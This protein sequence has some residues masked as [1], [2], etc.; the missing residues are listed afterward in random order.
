MYQHVVNELLEFMEYSGKSRQ[1]IAKET[2]ISSSAISQFLNGKYGGDNE[3]IAKNLIN[4]LKV[5]QK[6]VSAN[7]HTCFYEEL[8]NTKRV[9]V[10]CYHAH[11]RNDITLVFGDAGAGKTTALEYYRDTNAGV[12]MI[13]ANSCTAS[14][15]AILKLISQKIGKTITGKKDAL[16]N[17]LVNHFRGTNRLII[18]D[19]ADHLTIA[20]LQAVRN[21]NDEAKIGI[22]LSGNSKIYN[23]ML[24]GSKSS[25][26]QQLRTRIVVR[27]KVENLY[28]L[29]EF[30]HI[31]P[32][33]EDDCL[34]FLMEIA[35]EESLRTAVKI[36]NLLCDVSD[37][38]TLKDL[39]KKR[40]ELTE[41]L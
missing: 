34:G 24:I 41:G 10:A 12:V 30:R 38:I 13:T 16:M 6:R 9:L 36:L 25:E 37:K 28:T 7:K 3:E 26:L 27:R 14:A 20:A 2:G 29:E 19:E 31:F 18:I 15:S 4:Y 21:L 1:Q 32:G 5:A 8:D 35:Q 11:T 17:E 39:N 40:I 33:I 22:V 23:Q